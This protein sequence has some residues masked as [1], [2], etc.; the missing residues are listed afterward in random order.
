[1]I[2]KEKLID[3]NKFKAA[4]VLSLVLTIT[5]FLTSYAQAAT[6]TV[7]NQDE[8][9]NLPGAS[10]GTL[11][12]I[13]DSLNNNIKPEVTVPGAGAVVSGKN[14]QIKG[15]ASP[16]ANINILIEK[17][18]GGASPLIGKATADKYG[19][20][21]YFLGPE[22]TNGSYTIKVF[23][24]M[25]T[26]TPLASDVLTVT[27]KPGSPILDGSATESS[28]NEP[29]VIIIVALIFGSTLLIA[30]II[31]AVAWYLKSVQRTKLSGRM[32]KWEMPNMASMNEEQWK[33]FVAN[34][35][36]MQN[37]FS[38]SSHPQSVIQKTS[39]PG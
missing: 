13:Q 15:I 3:G 35:Q 29:F 30:M 6:N 22:L 38:A 31:W 26:E 5:G 19:V 20:W 12:Q 2:L 9:N 1:M 16:N 34:M 28:G 39:P 24:Q 36:E 27:V 11:Q 33:Q 18:L 10:S 17:T 7:I 21:S 37:K 14:L 4:F 32:D 25:N 8:I 23:S